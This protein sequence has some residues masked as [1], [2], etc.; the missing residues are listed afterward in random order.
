MVKGVEHLRP[1]FILALLL[2]SYI[3]S[4]YS[5][6]ETVTPPPAPIPEGNIFTVAALLAA[7][8]FLLWRKGGGRD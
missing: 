7:G 6:P 1:I 5:Q 2:V 3:P 4:V 8:L